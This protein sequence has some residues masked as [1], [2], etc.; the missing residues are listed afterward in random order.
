[1]ATLAKSS[2]GARLRTSSDNGETV[3]QG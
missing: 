3:T 1:M 2:W